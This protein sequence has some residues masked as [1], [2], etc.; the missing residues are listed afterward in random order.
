MTHGKAM[1]FVLFILSGG[2]VVRAGG[3]GD[4]DDVAAGEGEGEGDPLAAYV[5][6]CEDAAD[7]IRGARCGTSTDHCYTERD[8]LQESDGACFAEMSD[9]YEC[10]L[11]ST[12]TRDE[13]GECRHPCDPEPGVD[14]QV[15]CRQ[16]HPG[17]T[18]CIST[19]GAP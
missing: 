4:D 12:I 13:Y 17:V 16:E 9:W 14:C 11:Q 7:W 1:I 8:F 2:C 5:S 3:G 15:A 18:G 6:L 19:P 10:I